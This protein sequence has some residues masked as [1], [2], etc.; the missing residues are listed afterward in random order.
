MTKD[1]II[2]KEVEKFDEE[3]GDTLNSAAPFAF[4]SLREALTRLYEAWGKER[5]GEIRAYAEKSIAIHRQIIADHEICPFDWH[6]GNIKAF[7][8]VLTFL[9]T[10]PTPEERTSDLPPK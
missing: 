6:K 7:I 1:T 2:E 8:D 5:E 9:S 4:Q 10:P 3:Y